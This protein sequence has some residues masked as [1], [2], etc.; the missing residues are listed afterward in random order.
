MTIEARG[1]AIGRTEGRVTIEYPTHAAHAR[2]AAPISRNG[3]R[4]GRDL[5]I[6][7]L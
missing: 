2:D 6:G 5:R 4:N 1:E 3:F 7:T